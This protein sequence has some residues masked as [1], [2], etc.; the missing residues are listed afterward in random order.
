MFIAQLINTLIFVSP[1][2]G[3]LLV[4]AALEGGK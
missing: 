1:F 4:I 3:T 2:F